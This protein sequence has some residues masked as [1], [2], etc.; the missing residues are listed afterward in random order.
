MLG[1]SEWVRQIIEKS[2][3]EPMT[4]EAVLKSLERNIGQGEKTIE[5]VQAVLTYIDGELI[6]RRGGQVMRDLWTTVA[7][8]LE[9]VQE[10]S[11][12]A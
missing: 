7:D 5:R 9:K 10:A 4:T 6:D 8:Y 3:N 12:A 11:V 1:P 2:Q